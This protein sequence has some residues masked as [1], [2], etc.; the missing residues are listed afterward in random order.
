MMRKCI[1]IPWKT[2]NR[3]HQTTHIIILLLLM[4]HIYHALMAYHVIKIPPFKKSLNDDKIFQPKKVIA[5]NNLRK[6][7]EEVLKKK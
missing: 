7:L 1:F 5:G 2:E 6:I 4:C 3:Q